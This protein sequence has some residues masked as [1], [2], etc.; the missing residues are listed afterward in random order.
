MKVLRGPLVLHAVG[1]T[2]TERPERFFW[3]DALIP[4]PADAIAAMGLDELDAR[5]LREVGLPVGIDWTLVV[6]PPPHGTRPPMHDGEWIL[7]VDGPFPI[8]VERGGRIVVA[9]EPTGKLHVN[10]NVRAFGA[11]LVFYQEYRMRVRGLDETESQQLINDAEAKMRGTDPA[12][13]RDADAY[14]PV[15]LEQMRDGLL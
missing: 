15:I 8:C 14:W 12:A 13:M 10:A 3:G 5:Y 1:G 9:A 7:A 6:T 2:V 4:W 11:F